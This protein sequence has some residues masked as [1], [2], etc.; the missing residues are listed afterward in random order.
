MKVYWKNIKII[1]SDLAKYTSRPDSS[2]P[3]MNFVANYL[4]PKEKAAGWKLLWDGKTT[5]GWRGVKLNHF[6]K[7][8]WEI[9]D[10]VLTVL[11][12]NVGA[13]HG[14]DIITVKKYDNFELKVDFKVTKAANSGIKYFV[15]PEIN[16]GSDSAIG[17]E[18]QILDDKH[19]PDAQK[20]LAG[21]RTLASLYDLIT[22]HNDYGKRVNQYGWNQARIL[23]EGNHVEHWLN[24]IKMVE[25]Q[26]G[27]QIWR[28]LVAHTKFKNRPAFGQARK[29][30]IL[31]QDHRDEVHFRS[32]KIRELD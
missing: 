7:M 24:N 2:I 16:K 9:E 27:T 29:G 18:F 28:A 10:G 30:H 12:S 4:S 11:P 22:A 14:G 15:D 1:T 31:L 3:Q 21:N 5:K 13:A 20:G 23:V 19:H 25:Y 8:G 17:C 32:I 6:P 26:R